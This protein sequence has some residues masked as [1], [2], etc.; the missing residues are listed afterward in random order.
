MGTYK[1][2]MVKPIIT[3]RKG[4]SYP[5]LSIKIDQNK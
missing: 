2:A 1:L 3:K 4:V 5:K